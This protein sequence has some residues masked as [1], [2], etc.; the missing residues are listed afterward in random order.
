M[1]LDVAATANRLSMFLYVNPQFLPSSCCAVGTIPSTAKA[2]LRFL[3]AILKVQRKLQCSN[4]VRI[5][6]GFTQTPEN[7]V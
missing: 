5:P 4:K 7:E 2:L 6:K 3:H 1:H